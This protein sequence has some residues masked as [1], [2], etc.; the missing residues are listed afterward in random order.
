MT[1]SVSGFA[2]ASA[3]VGPAVFESS[4]I[5]A[6][7]F[8]NASSTFVP[9]SADVSKKNALCCFASS[10]PSLVGTSRVCCRSLLF[11]MIIVTTFLSAFCSSS[12]IHRGI[13]SNDV[14]FEMS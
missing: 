2:A 13:D 10:S 3:V 11:P 5:L 9:S 1:V 12:V 7:S 6:T 8:M 14:F 4:K